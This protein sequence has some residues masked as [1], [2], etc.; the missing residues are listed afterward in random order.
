[1]LADE[2]A[3]ARAADDEVLVADRVDFLGLEAVPRAERSQQ[4]EIARAIVAEQKVRADP[5]LRH[6][7]PLDEHP[8]YERLRVP[9]RQ[10]VRE[11]DDRRALD[12]GVF[13]RFELLRGR[14]DERRR[15]V[16]T[17]DTRRVRIE[18]HHDGGRPAFAGDPA[19]TLENLAVTAMQAVEVAEGQDRM[20]PA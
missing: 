20:R 2:T 13:E 15:L 10:L 7:E 4:R 8:P 5:D 18:R 6:T 16:G 12:A 14:H 3:D 19:Q 9:L 1:S 17:D 11:A